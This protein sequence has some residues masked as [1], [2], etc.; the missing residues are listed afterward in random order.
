MDTILARSHAQF[1]MVLSIP[2]PRAGKAFLKKQGG[3]FGMLKVAAGRPLGVQGEW[4]CRYDRYVI[5][6][7]SQW[8]HPLRSEPATQH[9]PGIVGDIGERSN[10]HPV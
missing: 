8:L 4:Q 6:A 2:T 9:G 5:G 7:N 1:K 3:Q 10:A